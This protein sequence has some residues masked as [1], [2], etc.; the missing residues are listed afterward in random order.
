MDAAVHQT[1]CHQSHQIDMQTVSVHHDC[2]LGNDLRLRGCS[3]SGEGSACC[4]D[5]HAKYSQVECSIAI[6]RYSATAVANNVC[7][8]EEKSEWERVGEQETG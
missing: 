7:V 6:I 1:D 3:A 5:S 2:L 4:T 8:D